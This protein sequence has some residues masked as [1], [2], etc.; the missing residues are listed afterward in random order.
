MPPPAA[1]ARALEAELAALAD[2]GRA[3]VLARFFK[4]GP[5]GYGEGDRFLGIRVPD[6]RRVIRRYRGL[7]L[8][9][10]LALLRSAYHEVRLAALLLMVDAHR[11]ADARGREAIFH[12]YLAHADRVNNWDLVDASAEHLVGL[13]VAPGDPE[14]L[15][16]LAGSGSVWERRIAMLATFHWTKRGEPGPALRLA[17]RLVDDPHDLIHKASGWMLREVGKRDAAAL[18]G[19]LRA[20]H[21]AMP[22]TMLRYA[23]ERLPPEARRAWLSGAPPPAGAA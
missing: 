11:R 10:I 22:R 21:A 12:A 23:I 16:R 18:D 8:D 6:V 17:A 19:F 7:P 1:D 3:A 5:G 9:A 2:P 15:L 14:L 4:T 20:H 13:H